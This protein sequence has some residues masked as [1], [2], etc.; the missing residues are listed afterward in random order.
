MKEVYPRSTALVAQ[1][2][3]N[4]RDLVSH[5]FALTE[6]DAAFQVALAREGLKVIVA[7]G[8]DGTAS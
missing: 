3:V 5:T 1:G 8:A 6:I 7:P 4:V 2:R